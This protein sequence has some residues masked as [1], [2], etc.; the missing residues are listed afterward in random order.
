MVRSVIETSRRPSIPDQVAA[1]KAML[2]GRGGLSHQE[3]D[4]TAARLI[5]MLEASLRKVLAES[6]LQPPISFAITGRSGAYVAEM[7]GYRLIPGNP[8]AL[9]FGLT[10]SAPLNATLGRTYSVQI[11]RPGHEGADFIVTSA[12]GVLFEAE[13]REVRPSVSAPLQFRIDT[14]AEGEVG[15]LLNMLIEEGR[16]SLRGQGYAN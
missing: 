4:A 6:D 13:L 10:G 12:S 7:E 15:D 16:A 1:A 14:I 11:A 5:E 2:I 9:Y 3:L 8:V